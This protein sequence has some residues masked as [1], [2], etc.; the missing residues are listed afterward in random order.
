MKIKFILKLSIK[1]TA[2]GL[3]GTVPHME[4]ALTTVTV[5]VHTAHLPR[6][7]TNE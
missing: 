7:T 4:H 2:A 3:S 1:G 6:T 5:H